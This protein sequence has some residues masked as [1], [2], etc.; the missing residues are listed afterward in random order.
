M[1]NS[2]KSVVVFLLLTLLCISNCVS[3]DVIHVKDIPAEGFLLESGWRFNV[4]D[5]PDYAQ[6]SFDDGNWVSI[7]PTLDIYT[8]LPEIPEG[9][10]WLRIHLSVD[11]AINHLVMQIDQSVASEI[12]M[13]GKLIHRLGVLD[14]NPDNIKAVNPNGKL[15][16]FPFEGGEQLLSI[17]FGRQPGVGYAMHWASSNPGIRIRLN[18]VEKAFSFYI[19]EHFVIDKHDYFLSGVFL[20]LGVLYMALYILYPS[21]RANLYFSVY[22]LLQLVVW[23]SFNS[24]REID[25]IETYVTFKNFI[26]VILVASHISLLMALYDLFKLRKDWLFVSMV[27]FG[28]VCIPV[29][30]FVY[31]YGWR[32]Y[33]GIYTNAFN[34]AVSWIAFDYF[35]S[36]RKAAWIVAIGSI[37]FMGVWATFSLRLFDIENPHDIFVVAHLSMPLAV[38]LYLGYDFAMTSRS[39]KQKL[40]EVSTL[41]KEKEH[42]LTQ[43]NEMLEKQVA[44]RTV[45]LKNSI[46][47]L[48]SAQAQLIQSEKMA[49]LGELTAGIAHE[50][51]NP[52]NFV[53]NFAEVNKELISEI[54]EA[55]DKG[56]L[57]E[58]RYIANTISENHEKINHHGK[59]A[60]AI[61]KSMLQHSRTSSRQKEL[62]DINAL[63]DEYIRLTY[64]GYR[65]KDKSFNAKITTNF[66]PSIPTINIVRQDIGRVLLNLINNALYAVSEKKKTNTDG[67]EPSVV[68]STKLVKASPDDATGGSKIEICVKDN[69][70]GIPESFKEKIFQP[71]FSTKPTGQGTGLGLSLSYDIIKV[72]GGEIFVRSVEGDGCEFI[73]RL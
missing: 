4:G 57:N 55:I 22:A 7:N 62:T 54:N 48:K 43:Q 56:N 6:P 40:V 67:F 31:G 11:S 47:E 38:S 17:R 18:T 61:V 46:E 30:I 14:E 72:H 63:C 29:A 9:I 60:D 25:W 5:N 39:L 65:A 32:L 41:S 44:E 10:C 68:L 50:I 36:N 8:S 20:I 13:N 64:H 49:S 27:A 21:Q 58:V 73:I 15:F 19:K 16:A 59:R 53:N 2:L 37:F 45:A 26:M 35:R 69:G 3:Q 71:F 51:Q 66:D 28:L 42:I 34:L 23:G 33:G 12:Y 52:L 70:N 24:I 1:I